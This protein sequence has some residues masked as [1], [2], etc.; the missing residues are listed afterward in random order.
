MPCKNPPAST[1]YRMWPRKAAR[2]HWFLNIK[3]WDK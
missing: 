3:K 2:N 1:G